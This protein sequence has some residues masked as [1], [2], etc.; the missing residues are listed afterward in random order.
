MD[1]ARESERVRTF[2]KALIEFNKGASK[3]DC[4]VKNISDTGAK[5]EVTS[6][7]SLPIEFSL[8]IPH[9]G[10][11]H[12]AKLMW[13][14]KDAVGVHFV[15]LDGRDAAPTRE[16]SS[17]ET[18]NARLHARVRDLTRRLEDLGQDPNVNQAE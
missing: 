11:R 9:R 14:E 13:R 16:T 1:Q 15:P 5:L 7:V 4:V 12:R 8:D 3:I 6:A 17:L 10:K 18:E 2:L